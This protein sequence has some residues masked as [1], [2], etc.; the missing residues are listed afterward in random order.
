[1]KNIR[2]CFV[3]AHGTGKTTLAFEVHKYLYRELHEKDVVLISESSDGAK[4]A[5][6]LEKNDPSYEEALIHYRA[7]LFYRTPEFISDRS[8]FD[9]LGYSIVKTGQLS[10]ELLQYALDVHKK[11]NPLLFY[12]PIAIPLV[13]ESHRPAN[14]KYQQHV[15]DSIKA[16][17][18]GAGVQ[19]HTI[20]RVD[21]VSR[22]TYIITVLRRH[23]DE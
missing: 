2:I 3:G 20:T 1:M 18:T 22:L 8:L 7:K 12:V 10:S 14:E 15:D 21:L 16:V 6:H 17:L 11:L 13:G 19:Y 9:P 23:I 4:K 5:L